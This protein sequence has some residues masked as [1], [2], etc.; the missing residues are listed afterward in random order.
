MIDVD[1]NAALLG[2]AAGAV[3]GGVFFMGLGLGIRLAL[4]ASKPVR[5]LMLSAVVRI[6]A[7]LASG[8]AVVWYSGP[9]TFPGFALAFVLTRTVATTLASVR[10]AGGESK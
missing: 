9:W 10:P 3:V 6:A 1:W 8:W 5:V 2:L 7:L 4:Q